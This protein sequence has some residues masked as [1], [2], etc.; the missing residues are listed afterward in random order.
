[1]IK[2]INQPELFLYILGLGTNFILLSVFGW[3]VYLFIVQRLCLPLDEISRQL[4]VLPYQW[5]SALIID[6]VHYIWFLL[7][8][9]I[10]SMLL[11]KLYIL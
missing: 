10:F 8:I 3:L 11:K 2:S 6:M 9:Y 5:T 4:M 7:L 1:M